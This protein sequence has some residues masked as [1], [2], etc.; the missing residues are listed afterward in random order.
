MDER[1]AFHGVLLYFAVLPFTLSDVYGAPLNCV[2]DFVFFAGL[3]LLES[4]TRTSGDTRRT[5]HVA[6][7]ALV[8]AGMLN[9]IW[10][11]FLVAAYLLLCAEVPIRAAAIPDDIRRKKTDWRIGIIYI[12]AAGIAYL[13]PRYGYG[14]RDPFRYWTD[15]LDFNTRH[16]STLWAGLLFLPLWILGLWNLYRKPWFM[17]RLFPLAMIY[18]IALVFQVHL[19][20]TVHL[21]PLLAL[22][23]PPAV[24]TIFG[25]GSRGESGA[26]S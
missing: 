26:V 18:A 2:N 5:A 23:L 7:L 3:A 14:P 8:T 12:A 22:I 24:V 16:A 4:I 11:V 17:R 21:P 19:S 9:E 1:T 25:G 6:F 13:L 15:H 20:E 10:P